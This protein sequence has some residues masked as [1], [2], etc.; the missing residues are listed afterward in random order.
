[1]VIHFTFFIINFFLEKKILA[2]STCLHSAG[3]G[4]GCAMY[5]EAHFR[6]CG[7]K[8]AVSKV[9]YLAI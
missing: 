3:A 7:T 9:A 4:E 8:T 6:F 2:V 1:M 5:C